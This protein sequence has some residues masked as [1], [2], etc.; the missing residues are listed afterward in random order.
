MALP[1]TASA[2]PAPGRFLLGS[3]VSLELPLS[4][5]GIFAI[6][7]EHPLDMTVQRLH[8]P[9]P[10]QHRITTAAAQHQ[11]LDRRLPFRQVG[12]FL[13]QAGDVVGGVAKRDELLAVR[14]Y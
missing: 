9:D 5:V 14:Q 10:R 3:L 8:D 1:R 6:G 12:L 2:S 7:I 11:D 4:P 13:R